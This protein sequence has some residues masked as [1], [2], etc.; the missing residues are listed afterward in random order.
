M[1]NELEMMRVLRLPPRSQLVVEVGRSRYRKL[2]EI[3]EAEVRQRV[4]A[5]IGEL[6]VFAGG[7]QT[8]V[9]AGVAPALESGPSRPAEAP[10][11]ERQARFL[12]SLERQK[13]A[14][15]AVTESGTAPAAAEMPIPPVAAEPPPAAPGIPPNSPASSFIQEIDAL[16]QEHVRAN[17][18]LAGRRINLEQ[19]PNGGLRIHVDGRYYDRPAEVEEKE[20]ELVI[21]KALQEWEAR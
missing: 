15:K 21:R 18:R 6:I 9:D 5:A 19:A 13:A 20:V 11:T 12:E 8:L 3:A 16:L 1:A 4:V 2:S 14:M 10:L 17:P 7:Y